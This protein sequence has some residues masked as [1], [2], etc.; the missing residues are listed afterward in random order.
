[1]PNMTSGSSAGLDHIVSFGEDNAGNLYLVDFGNGSGFNGQYPGPGLGEIFRLVPD[2]LPGDYD[3][4]G[5]VDAADYALWRDTIGSTSNFA[6]DGNSDG[7]VDQDDFLVWRTNFGNDR[8]L[9]PAAP[10]AVPEPAD[11]APLI[12]ALTAYG[13]AFGIRVRRNCATNRLIYIRELKTT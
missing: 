12:V 1:M 11:S 5:T 3:D 4:S 10:V 8:A 2:S 13:V 7:A 6:A 9:V